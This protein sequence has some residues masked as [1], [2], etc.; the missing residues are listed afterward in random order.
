MISSDR[1]GLE[2]Q[3]FAHLCDTAEPT[4]EMATAIPDS[5]VKR[6]KL[7]LS[8]DKEAFSGNTAKKKKK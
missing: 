4:S 1:I 2:T 6:K 7:H 8:H 3:D 5:V